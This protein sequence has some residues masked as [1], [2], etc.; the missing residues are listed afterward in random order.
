MVPVADWCLHAKDEVVKIV[1]R[2]EVGAGGKAVR[3]APNTFRCLEGMYVPQDYLDLTRELANEEL[4]LTASRV[5]ELA[6]TI[7]RR[8]HWSW[9]LLHPELTAQDIHPSRRV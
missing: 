4:K 9:V 2:M 7:I 1:A 3:V 8:R 5:K 6:T